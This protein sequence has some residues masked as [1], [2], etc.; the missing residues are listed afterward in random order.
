MKVSGYHFT[1]NSFMNYVDSSHNC[2]VLVCIGLDYLTVNFIY[3]Q[4]PQWK[5]VT[6]MCKFNKGFSKGINNE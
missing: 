2:I 6:N 1:R 3:S 5:Y 4:L